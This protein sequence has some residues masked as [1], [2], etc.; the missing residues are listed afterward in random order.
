[1]A[2]LVRLSEEQIAQLF[3]EADSMENAL[4]ELHAELIDNG[5][6][7]ETLARFARIHDRFTEVMTFLRRQRDL[8]IN[9]ET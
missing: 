9:P 4:K 1:M 5:T 3:E 7:R 8:G 6:P 2:T